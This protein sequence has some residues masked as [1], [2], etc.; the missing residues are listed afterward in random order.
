MAVILTEPVYVCDLCGRRPLGHS[1]EIGKY[2]G[3]GLHVRGGIGTKEAHLSADNV[4]NTKKHLC[5]Y[6]LADLRRIIATYERRFGLP[7]RG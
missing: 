5:A 2:S 1:M 4:S 7:K 6:C 3:T